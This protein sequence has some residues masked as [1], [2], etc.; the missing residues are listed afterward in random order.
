M[1]TQQDIFVDGFENHPS[2]LSKDNY[3]QWS[4]R[5][6]RYC[7][8]KPNGKRL[9]KSILEGPYKYQYIP[10]PGDETRT[11]PVPPSYIIQS[12]FC[13]NAHAMWQRD[14]RLMK[15]TKTRILE[16]KLILLDELDRFPSTE[17]QNGNWII[18][19]PQGNI[20][21]LVVGNFGNEHNVTQIWCYNCRGLGHYA[22]NCTNKTRVRDS[23]YYIER[24]MLV[25]QEEAGIPFTVEQHDFIAA[26]YHEE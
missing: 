20:A 26:A 6:I 11:P 18:G 1:A 13:E 9:A 14:Q 16:K 8:R 2:M 25:Q 7:K 4:S 22:R 5:M 10:E 21:T 24:L 19:N 23:T 12:E 3:V 17:G 15:G